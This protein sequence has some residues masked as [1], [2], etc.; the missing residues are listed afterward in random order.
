MISRRVVLG[1][2]ALGSVALF[3]AGA[4][5]AWKTG[6]IQV[7]PADLPDIQLPP[8]DGV[9]RNGVAVPGICTRKRGDQTLLLNFWA[10]WCP[11]CRSEHALLMELAK[12]PRLTLVGVVTDDSAGPVAKYLAEAG[13]PYHQL[14][15]DS[16][17]E[18]V[19]SMRQRGIPT[20]ML[21]RPGQTRVSFRH[22]GPLDE[23]VIQERILAALGPR[24]GEG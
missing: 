12:D 2:G 19:R 18:I 15:I 14:S 9:T 23:S 21:V 24:H 3:G 4:Y 10:S 22:I 20:T 1:L 5:G 13:N 6:R 8:V 16:K 7:G 17:R 11:Y